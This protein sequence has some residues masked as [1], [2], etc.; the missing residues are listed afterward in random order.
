MTDTITIIGNL[1]AEPEHRVTTGGASVTNFR[2]GSTH[3]RY[4]KGSEQWVDAFTN[5][6]Q[7]SAFRALG[8]NAHASLH[9]GDRVIVTG[10]LRLREWDNGTKRGL[11][12]ELEAE[13]IGHDLLRGSTT[14]SKSGISRGTGTP[15]SEAAAAGESYA[16]DA[17]P[18]E[19]RP[20]VVDAGGWA[21]PAASA[22]PT[23]PA[24]AATLVDT[25][26]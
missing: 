24:S 9:K 6:Y 5:W 18:D 12:V 26:F 20:A 8:D 15:D 22:E 17:L 4:D 23:T 11:A 13:A 7:V 3:R 19:R 2:V 16:D 10:R 25:P 1:A 21:I 14:F